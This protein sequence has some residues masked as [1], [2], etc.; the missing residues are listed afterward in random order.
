[1][2]KNYINSNLRQILFVPSICVLLIILAVSSVDVV[3]AEEVI[4][5]I[6]VGF[7]PI[8][9]TF[10]P[11][12]N[13]MYIANADSD[14][15]SVINS[16]NHTVIATIPVGDLTITSFDSPMEYNPFNNNIYVT[17]DGSNTVSVINS[18]T[19]TVTTTI[20]VGVAPF[21]PEFNSFD[22]NMYIMN[23]GGTVS[24]IDSSTNTVIDTITVQINPQ[25]ILYNPFNNNMYVANTGSGTVSVI[26]VISG[27]VIATIPVESTP[28]D[29]EF[30]PANNHI[31]VSNFNDASVSVID[32][33]SNT[34][35]TTISVDT[36]PSDLEFNPFNDSI[37]VAHSGGGTGAPV[38]V[39][40]SS[41]TIS[42]VVP[43]GKSTFN[44][45]FNEFNTNMYVSTSSLTANNV[46]EVIN[47]TSN[48][49]IDT[50][51]VGNNPDRLRFNP[52][53]N[54]IYAANRGSQSV[55]V[56][57]PIPETIFINAT[58]GNGN[59]V[60]NFT[61]T[62]STSIEINVEI[63]NQYD[64]DGVIC[65]LN[66]NLYDGCEQFDDPIGDDPEADLK[67]CTIEDG[68]V[69]V[70]QFTIFIDELEV[71]MNN[72]SIAAFE[73]AFE[74]EEPS[75]SAINNEMF[76]N[77]FSPSQNGIK[78]EQGNRELSLMNS[79]L[80]FGLQDNNNIESTTNLTSTTPTKTNISLFP[81]SLTQL[82]LGNSAIDVDNEIKLLNNEKEHSVPV[83]RNSLN[84]V[85]TLPLLGSN[86][87]DNI[88]QLSF[89]ESE[90][91]VIQHDPETDDIIVDPTP[92]TLLWEV[93]QEEPLDTNITSAEDGNEDPVG[94]ES[95]TSSTIITFTFTAENNTT[96]A[97]F[98]CVLDNVIVD[99]CSEGFI[100]YEGLEI[101]VEHT[102]RVNAYIPNGGEGDVDTTP[103]TWVWTILEEPIV[104][105][106]ILEAVDGNDEEIMT[107]DSTTSNDINFT[108]SGVV[109]TSLSPPFGM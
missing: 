12:N 17:N 6:P 43:I 80:S 89:N 67:E 77:K 63:R 13:N 45:E 105:E 28:R 18:S 79:K 109:S 39:I 70:C 68:D 75:F 31:Y 53:N 50:V 30:N 42:A 84:A 44:L 21:E 47:S 24:V 1:M 101:G 86:S 32:S 40:D 49:V 46:V 33:I 82:I 83:D 59:P 100:T 61:S 41:D 51:T 19:N 3:F 23:R 78:N 55:S 10:N 98:T 107:G 65:Y 60:V 22:N 36:G 102:F 73:E 96:N 20:P 91:L 87:Y 103:A 26:D 8:G 62:T 90:K 54:Y 25:N 38:E 108:F 72:F 35:I 4:A 85:D 57:G 56:I 81:L 95:S 52:E 15:V 71:G 34:V 29:L 93:L 88:D 9:L 92:I 64:V 69:E 48:T 7:S 94:N 97:G 106:T 5:T 66:Q 76:S 37:Y 27:T 16:N 2:V 11:F 74:V 14:T 104:V 99:D 58:D